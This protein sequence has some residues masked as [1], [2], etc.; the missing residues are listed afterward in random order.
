MYNQ[1]YKYCP[2]CATPLERRERFGQVRPVCPTCGFVYFQDP[3]VAVI[4]FVVRDERLLLIRRAVDPAKGKWALPGGYMDAG[5]MPD[6]ALKREMWEEVGLDIDVE[7]LLEIYPMA[8]PGVDAR[9]IVLAYAAVP[10]N[11]VDGRPLEA[12]DDVSE[13]GWFAPDEI[14]DE[15]AFESTRA[16]LAAWRDRREKA[17][18]I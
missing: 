15:L 16:L 11:H 3:K 5:E 4:G 13:A 14:P 2:Y 10:T 18:A 1:T 12:H 17:D 7:R 8:G 6:R 9:G